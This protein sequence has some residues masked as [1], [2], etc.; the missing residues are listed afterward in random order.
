MTRKD[1]LRSDP[2]WLDN[3]ALPE[4]PPARVERLSAAT[5]YATGNAAE[6]WAAS[7]PNLA[8]AQRRREITARPWVP[9]PFAKAW[10]ECLA[11]R[12][13]VPASP[14]PEPRDSVVDW[15]GAVFTI[16]LVAGCV[17]AAYL[18]IR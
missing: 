18:T 14:E 15:F 4:D 12:A 17:F 8:I 3:L 10:A 6:R 11:S 16:L 5:A 13:T 2:A 1:A 9:G 7:L